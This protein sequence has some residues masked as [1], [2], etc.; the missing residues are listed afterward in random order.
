MRYLYYIPNHHKN[1]AIKKAEKKRLKAEA[2]IRKKEIKANTNI[3]SGS[4]KSKT[5]EVVRF[6]EGVKGSLYIILAL[7]LICAIILGQTGVIM[8][9][10]DI[11]EN[12]IL[13][14]AG[15]VLLGIIA[16]ALFIYGLKNLRVV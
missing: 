8:T 5:T 3:G 12:L 1:K 16:L 11:I 7:S 9:L 2:K 13:A 15:K 14:T 10:E 4:P 6:A